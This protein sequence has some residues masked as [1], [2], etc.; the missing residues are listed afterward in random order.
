MS[1]QTAVEW[2]SE[3][4]AKMGYVSTNIL[5]QAKE[6]EKEQMKEMYLKG[7]ANYDPTFKIKESKGGDRKPKQDLEKEMFDLEQELDIPSSMRWHNSKPKQETL[8]EAAAKYVETKWEPAQEENRE[9]FIAGAKSEAARD[10]WFEQ[11]KK[12]GGNK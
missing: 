4:V 6:M 9:S 1:K 7:I 5:E 8:E 12:K 2:F 10:Y 3:V 11:F